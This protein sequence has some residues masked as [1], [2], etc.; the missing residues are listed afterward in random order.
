[1][2]STSAISTPIPTINSRLH[3]ECGSLLV[4]SLEG[5]PLFRQSPRQIWSGNDTV[6]RSQWICVFLFGLYLKDCGSHENTQAEA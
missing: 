5:L 6:S 4:L 2:R 1:M 3:L